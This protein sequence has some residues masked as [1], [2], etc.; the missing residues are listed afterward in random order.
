M[1]ISRDI[2]DKMEEGGNGAKSWVETI[3]HFVEF[4]VEAPA[5][6]LNGKNTPAENSPP[7]SFTD[8]TLFE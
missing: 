1:K 4:A 7:S 5:R 2:E 6:T 3:F 8:S